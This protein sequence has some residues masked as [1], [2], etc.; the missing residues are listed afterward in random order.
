MVLLHL[1]GTG[2]LS[3][4]EL[5]AMTMKCLRMRDIVRTLLSGSVASKG[6]GDRGSGVNLF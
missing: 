5:K 1:E 3:Q 4:Y 6:P 2:P